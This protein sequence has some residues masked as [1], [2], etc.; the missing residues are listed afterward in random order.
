MLYVTTRSNQEVYTPQRVLRENRGPDG[1]MFL[2]FHMPTLSAEE[3]EALLTLPVNDCV[4]RVLN[5]L[6]RLNLTALDVDFAVGRHPI[7]L[8]TLPHRIFIGELWHN[9]SW[10]YAGLERS[11]REKLS[12]D[13]ENIGGWVK[14]AVRIAGLFG[15]FALLKE[16]GV[17]QA[18]VSVVS[19]DFS[20]PISALYARELGL[21]VR[22]VICSCNE[23]HSLWDLICHGQMRTSSISTPTMIPEADV[24]VPEELERLIALRGGTRD[25][26]DFLECCR[27][28]KMY[29]PSDSLLG[30]M[31]E[32]LYVSVVSSVRLETTIPSVYRSHGYL[33]SA[34]TALAYGGLL[35]YRAQTGNTAAA[36]VLSD[37]GP[38]KDARNVCRCLGILEEELKTLL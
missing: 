24:A 32:G 15:L 9:P 6:F 3:R 11:L 22:N 19:G 2:P 4:C 1:G 28:G 16:A 27:Q 33:M 8:H 36:L 31:K 20:A 23:N 30:R 37:N 5:L 10:D 35:D 34:H 14:I 7:R 17:D 25:V 12:A 38:G 13:P 18:D 29:V 26:E 21:P